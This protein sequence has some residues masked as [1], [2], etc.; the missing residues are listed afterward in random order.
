MDTC[1]R[2][3]LAAG[4][5][6]ATAL[7]MG[8]A[9]GGEGGEAATTP[10]AT[11]GAG[12]LAAP[13]TSTGEPGESPSNGGEELASASEIP[14]GGGKVFASEKVVVTQPTAGDFK[15]FSAICT[16]QGCTVRTVADGTI[17][18]PCHDSKFSVT[19]GSVVEGPATRPL[20]SKQITVSGDTITLA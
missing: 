3:V 11:G 7:V 2:T 1:R 10:P 13:P 14:V 16:H 19:D 9:G 5:V 20:P 6:G 4:A 8:C 12:T 15:A 17:D 18:C